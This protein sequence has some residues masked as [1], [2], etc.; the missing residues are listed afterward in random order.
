MELVNAQEAPADSRPALRLRGLPGPL[1]AK[2]ARN[3]QPAESNRSRP[4]SSSSGS[5]SG[6]VSSPEPIGTLE[7]ILRTEAGKA[8]S[9]QAK[10]IELAGQRVATG[11]D[12]DSTTGRLLPG[13]KALL[14]DEATATQLRDEL[15][16][17]TFRVDEVAE[18][19]FTQKA[20]PPFITSSLQQEAAR[21]LR[22]TVQRTMRLAQTL[23]ENG[24]ITYMRTDSTN[25]SE[26]AIQ[27]ARSQVTALYGRTTLRPSRESIAPSQRG[28]RKLTKPSARPARPSAPP[29]RSKASWNRTPSGSTS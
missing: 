21:K 11:K 7:A 24:F 2:S 6:C 9:I 13:A 20:H 23:Y 12:F 28:P 15:Q 29:K 8:Q 14:V 16:K 19:P 26:Q 4:G 18:K 10:L 27:A 5:G 1:G 25:L 3:S 17:Q 22:F